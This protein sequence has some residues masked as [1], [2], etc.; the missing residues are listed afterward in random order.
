MLS[1]PEPEDQALVGSP[2]HG[3]PLSRGDSMQKDVPED[4]EMAGHPLR[5]PDT[6]VVLEFNP[7]SRGKLCLVWCSL[8]LVSLHPRVELKFPAIL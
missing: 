4:Q 1:E 2:S 5:G 7:A 3:T 8:S 6:L